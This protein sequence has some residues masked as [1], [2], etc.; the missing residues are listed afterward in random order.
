MN[1]TLARTEDDPVHNFGV[2]SVDGRPFGQTLE[3]PDR[4]LEDLPD[5]K[6]PGNTAIPRGRYRVVLTLSSR[7]RRVMPEVLGVPGFTGVRI[8]G[9]NTEADTSGCPLLGRVRTETGVA[10]CRDVNEQF[11]DLISEALSRGEE[12]WLEVT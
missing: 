7:F 8:H 9:G 4:H 11:I 3:D 6:V 5:A 1:I 12:C 10:Q 2:L